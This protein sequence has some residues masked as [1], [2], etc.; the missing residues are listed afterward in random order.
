MPY[1]TK[2]PAGAHQAILAAAALSHV[3]ACGAVQRAGFAWQSCAISPYT[4]V[5]D[6]CTCLSYLVLASSTY[7]SRTWRLEA[8]HGDLYGVDASTEWE[9]VVVLDVH[10][11]EFVP[12][13]WVVNRRDVHK[14]GFLALRGVSKAVPL[15]AVALAR[16]GPRVC[17][18]P[19][20]ARK[21]FCDFMVTRHQL[22]RR[23]GALP[24]RERDLLHASLAESGCSMEL[25]EELAA[26]LVADQKNRRGC[27]R[28]QGHGPGQ[29]GM[30]CQQ[31]GRV[32]HR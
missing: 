13:T 12:T 6:K 16:L 17:R 21:E 10:Q 29:E 5:R 1:V 24:D 3:W 4:V 32:R 20:W 28:C 9:W 18:L 8:I 19:A 30:R 25:R 26:R 31:G 14:F 23:D 27:S 15:V 7:A 11:W 22:G 2:S